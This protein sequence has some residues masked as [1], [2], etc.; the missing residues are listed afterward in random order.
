MCTLAK[1]FGE[2][3]SN[4]IDFLL[5]LATLGNATQA[6]SFLFAKVSEEGDITL[7]FANGNT[8]LRFI[9]IGDVFYSDKADDI[10]M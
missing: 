5:A 2:N 8:V 6:G 1:Y 10:H 7:N 9:Y 3:A 4:R